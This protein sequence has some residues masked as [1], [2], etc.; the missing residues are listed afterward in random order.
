MGAEPPYPSTLWPST[1]LP[2]T[3]RSSAEQHWAPVRGERGDLRESALNS[4]RE[5]VR[6]GDVLSG[7]VLCGGRSTR[8]GRDKARL[9]LTEDETMLERAVRALA[10][11]TPD[12]RLACGLEPRYTELGRPLVLDRFDASGPLAGL[13]SALSSAPA[14]LVI[15]VACDMPRLDARVLSALVDAAR[16]RDLDVALLRSARGLEPLC[17]VW[18]TSMAH[19]VRA[20]LDRGDRRVVAAFDTPLANGSLPRVAALEAADLQESDHAPELSDCAFNVNTPEDFERERA[21]FQRAEK[22][23]DA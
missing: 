5:E 14:G 15:V 12:V 22:A 16:Q 19:A 18:R 3:L 7:I 17:G 23:E 9:A 20:A 8:M 4:A 10:L 21:S 6:D 13:E 2:P 11:L 1:R